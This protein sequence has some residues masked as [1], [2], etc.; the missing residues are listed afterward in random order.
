MLPVSLIC[1]T[2]K[3]EQTIYRLLD[4]VRQQSQM[5]SEIIIADASPD[6]NTAA[7]VENYQQNYPVPINLIRTSGNRSK[8]RN[9]AIEN[10][11][12]PVIAATDAGCILDTQWLEKITATILSGHADSVA[13]YYYPLIHKPFHKALAP[14]VAV[15]PDKFDPDTYLPSSR[16]VAF[17]KPAWEKAGKYPEN[18]RYNEDIIFAANLKKQTRMQVRGDAIVHWQMAPNL[19]VYF[20]QIKNYAI[21]DIQFNYQP[22]VTKILSIYL[23]YLVF[24]TYPA[25]FMAYTVT[26]PIYKH[27]NH[28]KTNQ[29]RAYLPAIQLVT[30][31]AILTG[32]AIAAFNLMTPLVRQTVDQ[33]FNP[34]RQ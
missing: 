31:L 24:I 8:G 27:R 19:A 34:I 16:S 1:T 3:E 28:V 4:S 23:R 7:I 15:M 10:A 6:S 21:G 18:N 32:G 22:H 33:K 11:V 14:F 26:W 17:T 30:D 12:Y 20:N 25:L 2:Y 9:L 5:P 29:D 13:G